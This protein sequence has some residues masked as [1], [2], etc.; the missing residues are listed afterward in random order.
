MEF[1]LENIANRNIL[2]FAVGRQ[3][4]CPACKRSL[5]VSDAI[6]CSTGKQ[7]ATFCSGCY[8]ALSAPEF[9]M[10]GKLWAGLDPEIIDG[11]DLV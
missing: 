1:T 7:Q 6:H 3:V 8:A 11:R 9:G 2:A 5:T 4:F 10:W